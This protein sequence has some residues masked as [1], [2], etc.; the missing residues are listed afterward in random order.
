MTDTAQWP[1]R[2][3]VFSFEHETAGDQR[4]QP[5]IALAMLEYIRADARGEMTEFTAS[6]GVRVHIEP[7]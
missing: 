7:A 5:M 2:R 3:V 6:N 4:F 1:K